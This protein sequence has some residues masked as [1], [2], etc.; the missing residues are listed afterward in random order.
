MQESH[1]LRTTM[2]RDEREITDRTEIDD[3]IRHARLMRIAL[4]DGDR[5]FLVPV[6]YGYDGTS[7]YFHSA[8]KGS[9]IE[10]LKK[11]NNICF[12][13]G[14]DHGVIEDESPCDFE[15]RHRTVIG[16]GKA[17]FVTDKAEKIRALDCIVASFTERQF[18]YP[19]TNLNN[20]A[21]LRIDI[22][23]LKGK[24]HGF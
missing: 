2:R 7:L 16:H 1:P 18:T 6:F 24:K 4:V 22:E 11:N 10:I 15:A 9:K 17:S 13:I 8:R 12:E 14:L 23:V 5:P 20:T 21:V 3:I 19:E